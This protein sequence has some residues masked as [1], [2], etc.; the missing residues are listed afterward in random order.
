MIFVWE[1]LTA[2]KWPGRSPSESGPS[3]AMKSTAVSI[4]SIGGRVSTFAIVLA[5]RCSLALPA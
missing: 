2:K 1:S 4:L 5:V 3:N